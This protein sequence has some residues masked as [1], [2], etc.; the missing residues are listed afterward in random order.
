MRAKYMKQPTRFRW[1]V[2]RSSHLNFVG[3]SPRARS[4][5]GQMILEFTFSMIIVMVM[6]F[7]LVMILKWSGKD[8][9]Q[10]RLSHEELLKNPSLEPGEQL[11]PYFYEPETFDATFAVGK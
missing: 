3:L 6:I 10:R 7:S 8:N 1:P 2:V 9:A 4:T 11:D 5:R